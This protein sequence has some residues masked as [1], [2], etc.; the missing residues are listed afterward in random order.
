MGAWIEIGNKW[1][2]SPDYLVAPLVGAWIEIHY[3]GMHGRYGSVA[4][5]VGAWIEILVDADLDGLRLG[6]APRGRVD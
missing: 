6:R 3:S 2:Y 5:L 1:L 4:P